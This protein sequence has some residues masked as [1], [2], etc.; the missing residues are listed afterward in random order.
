MT[1]AEIPK[2]E[3]V[4]RL[5]SPK[6]NEKFA[7]VLR[8]SLQVAEDQN[9]SQ[10]VS[11]QHQGGGIAIVSRGRLKVCRKQRLTKFNSLS[12]IS[13]RRYGAVGPTTQSTGQRTLNPGV[14]RI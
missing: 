6:N 14:R 1:L 4:I 5:P 2:P 11:I 8:V 9:L 12:S 3:G 13:P 7:R 10:V